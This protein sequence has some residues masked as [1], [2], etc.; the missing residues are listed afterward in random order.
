M[1]VRDGAGDVIGAVE[2]SSDIGEIKQLAE[3][4][5]NL[6]EIQSMLEAIFHSTQD[7]ISV[8][9]Q[10]GMGVM[11][12]PAYTRLTG[13]SEKDV[14]G[15]PATVDIAEGES[16]HFKVLETRKPIKSARLKVGPSRKEVIVDAAPIVVDGNWGKR[17]SD[18]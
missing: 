3:Q 5:T 4:I 7:A 14:I 9:D 12:N 10:H 6:K 16:I 15:K 8:V 18:S 2:V 1:P 13:L 11:V 17:R